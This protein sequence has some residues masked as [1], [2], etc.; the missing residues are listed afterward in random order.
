MLGFFGAGYLTLTYHTYWNL[1]P[2]LT[3]IESIDAPITDLIFPTVTVCQEPLTPAKPWNL[4]A[5]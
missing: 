3:T 2:I 4:L 5:H 1:R